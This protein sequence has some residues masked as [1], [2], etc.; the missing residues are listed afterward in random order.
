MGDRQM[1]VD[2]SWHDGL[3][4]DPSTGTAE[5]LS[6]RQTLNCCTPDTL[7]RR[8]F[9]PLVGL[10][11]FALRPTTNKASNRAYVKD[12]L[13]SPLDWLSNFFCISSERLLDQSAH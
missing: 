11:M 5:L 2:Q 8:S 3:R 10:A 6:S 7:S 4:R 12:V 9:L 1:R 13:T